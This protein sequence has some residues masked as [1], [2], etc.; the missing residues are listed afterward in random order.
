MKQ[1]TPPDELIAAL[2]P[3]PVD[4]SIGAGADSKG[5]DA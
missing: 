3:N 5:G 2:S 1:I 4:D